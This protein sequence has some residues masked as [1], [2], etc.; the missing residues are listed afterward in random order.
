M[1]SPGPLY[2]SVPYRTAPTVRL[3]FHNMAMLNMYSPGSLITFPMLT[4]IEEMIDE[5]QKAENEQTF[6]NSFSEPSGH[7]SSMEARRNELADS[8]NSFPSVEM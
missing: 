2:E 8:S 3:I 5:S 7:H 6:P 1:K 4:E